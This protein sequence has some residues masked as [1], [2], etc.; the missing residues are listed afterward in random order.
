MIECNLVL[1][2]IAKDLKL[3]AKDDSLSINAKQ[4]EHLI[5]MLIYLINTKSKLFFVIGILSRFMHNLEI[6]H[7][8]ATIIFLDALKVP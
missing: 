7:L 6:P 8:E 3:G 5:D 2:Y 4:Y 1:L